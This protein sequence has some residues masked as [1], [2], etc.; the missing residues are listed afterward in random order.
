MSRK[1]HGKSPALNL[2]NNA[3]RHNPREKPSQSGAWCWQ[4]KSARR[5]IRERMNGDSK[6]VYVLSVYDALT[7]IASDESSE[8]FKTSHPY[9]AEKAGCGIS[10]LKIALAELVE[11]GLVLIDTPIMRGPCT[12]TLVSLK[13]EAPVSHNT[14]SDSRN[15]ANVSHKPN[16]SAVATVEENQKKGLEEKQKNEDAAIVEAWNKTTLTKCQN[17]ANGRISNLKARLENDFW[18]ENW[19]QGLEIIAA[20]PFCRGENDRGWVADIDWFIRSDDA[21]TKALE[22][23]YDAKTKAVRTSS[24]PDF[25]VWHPIIDSLCREMNEREVDVSEAS[26]QLKRALEHSKPAVILNYIAALCGQVPDAWREL[27]ESLPGEGSK[28]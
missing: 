8:I 25:Q 27:I 17:L 7:E 11:A 15:T 26:L 3:A 6:T 5:L 18:R 9:L 14:A 21:V 19:R 13:D 28:Q 1:A 16:L 20:S 12:F 23:K 4:Q 10:Q 22:G 24:I 2:S